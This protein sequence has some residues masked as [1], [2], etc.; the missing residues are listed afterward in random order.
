LNRNHMLHRTGNRHTHWTSPSPVD[1]PKMATV[2]RVPRTQLVRGA[3]VWAHVPYEE[4][5][6][7]KSRPAV[8]V[9]LRGRDLTLLPATTSRSRHLFT[10]RYIEVHD[11]AAA[12][13][14]RATAIRTTPVTVD[15]IEVINIIGALSGTDVQRTLGDPSEEGHDHVAA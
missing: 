15:I 6:G 5:N 7:E 3:V 9:E 11:L 2:R 4:D 14:S 8:V 1:F 13:L 12:G 10:G